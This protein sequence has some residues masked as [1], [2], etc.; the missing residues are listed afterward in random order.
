MPRAQ[1]LKL[2]F[3]LLDNPQWSV[4][5]KDRLLE[6]LM[7]Y[8]DI[9]ISMKIYIVKFYFVDTRLRLLN[10]VSGTQHMI[11]D[12]LQFCEHLF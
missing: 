8:L 4:M 9:L 6:V 1:Y 2:K 3:S 11:M 5:P 12:L 10:T 7:L